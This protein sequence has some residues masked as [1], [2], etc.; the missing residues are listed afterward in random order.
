MI[1]T[2]DTN[3]LDSADAFGELLRE[4]CFVEPY[5]CYSCFDLIEEFEEVSFGEREFTLLLGRLP[6]YESHEKED[7]KFWGWDVR[8]DEYIISKAQWYYSSKNDIEIGWYW[9]GDGTL[10]IR[11]GNKAVEN[12]DCKKDHYWEWVELNDDQERIL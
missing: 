8:E 10:F 4:Y 2:I 12:G 7:S 11:C 9:D 6:T 3:T 5:G 1:I